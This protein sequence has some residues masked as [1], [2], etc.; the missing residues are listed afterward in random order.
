MTASYL[1]A[2]YLD[3]LGIASSMSQEHVDYYQQ[4]GSLFCVVYDLSTVGGYC[5]SAAGALGPMW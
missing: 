5:L 1:A 3:F 2:E 4:K